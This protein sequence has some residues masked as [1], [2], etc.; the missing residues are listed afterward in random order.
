ML[1]DGRS[2]PPDRHSFRLPVSSEIR[3]PGLEVEVHVLRSSDTEKK[4]VL[5]T[6]L[7]E[8][9]RANSHRPGFN[10]DYTDKSFATLND[11]TVIVVLGLKSGG[12]LGYAS[13]RESGPGKSIGEVSELDG[14]TDQ[15]SGPIV[16]LDGTEVTRATL[17]NYPGYHAYTGEGK[18]LIIGMIQSFYHRAGVGS[19][20][21][22]VIKDMGYELIDAEANGDDEIAFFEANGFQD[23]N[24][25][26]SGGDQ[27][28]IVWTKHEEE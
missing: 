23:S 19:R 28:I 10:F 5:D 24:L 6:A 15:K 17:A 11:N 4:A 26:C 22:S 1:D 9:I 21:L 7:A 14:F 8:T 20:L 27:M 18:V 3:S 25:T 12:I 13:C 2:R 16:D